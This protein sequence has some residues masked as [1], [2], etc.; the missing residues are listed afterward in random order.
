MH[1][2]RFLLMKKSG[3][4]PTQVET[5]GSF[6]RF[7]FIWISKEKLFIGEYCLQVLDWVYFYKCSFYLPLNIYT[8][9]KSG[10]GD[11]STCH[12]L[13]SQNIIIDYW[14]QELSCCGASTYQASPVDCYHS[15]WAS[16]AVLL[17]LQSVEK[18]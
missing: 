11:A 8:F 9:N 5:C 14:H 18:L 15:L 10:L 16:T 7:P 4:I 17:L 13:H 3:S 12:N 2:C 1:H 6:L